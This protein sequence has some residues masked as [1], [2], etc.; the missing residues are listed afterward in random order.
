MA[1]EARRRSEGRRV[2][3]HGFATRSEQHRAAAYDLPQRHRR[4]RRDAL[5]RR[6]H[7]L[8]QAGALF[9]ARGSVCGDASC[10]AD[11]SP[12]RFFFCSATKD[13]A[14]YDYAYEVTPFVKP[15]GRGRRA[16]DHRRFAVSAARRAL[17]NRERRRNRRRRSR[18]RSVRPLLDAGAGDHRCHRE[19]K[20]G[21]RTHHV[22]RLS[23][24]R[25]AAAVDVRAAEAA[26]A[27]GP[28]P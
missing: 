5:G 23:F 18:L 14:H 2:H 10:A 11:R 22:G 15:V 4:S 7:A 13:G 20:A 27:G 1:I 26:S 19:R 21:A 24:P 6:R 9:D 16:R 12:I 28:L 8:A 3:V 25:S 17:S